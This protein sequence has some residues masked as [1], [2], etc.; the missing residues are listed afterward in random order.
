MKEVWDTVKE[1][2]A[3]STIKR[4]PWTSILGMSLTKAIKLNRLRGYDSK[5]TYW[6]L[7]N[8]PKVQEY[9]R[10]FPNMTDKIKENL[11]ISV[12]ARYGESKTEESIK[13]QVEEEHGSS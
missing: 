9:I 8:N 13:R 3:K 1:Q 12:A 7:L 2:I 4:F 6:Y 5:T 10:N 11:K